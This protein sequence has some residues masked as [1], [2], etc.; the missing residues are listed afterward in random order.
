MLTNVSEKLTS[1]LIT[2]ANATEALATA[3]NFQ[4][5]SQL[6]HVI[7]TIESML[8][9]RFWLGNGW[10]NPILTAVDDLAYIHALE[11]VLFIQP[12]IGILA[13]AGNKLGIY[14]MYSI[15]YELYTEFNTALKPLRQDSQRK[16]LTVHRRVRL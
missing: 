7:Q 4:P 5:G 3:L 6:R 14:E 10:S 9:F 13:T 2:V 12:Q 16:W 15:V 8:V 11:Q 1:R